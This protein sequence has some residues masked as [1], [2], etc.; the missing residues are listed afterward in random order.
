MW[1]WA[2][3]VQGCLPDCWAVFLFSMHCIEFCCSETGVFW[4]LVMVID[5]VAIVTMINEADVQ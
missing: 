4:R 3:L 2:M 5:L 1:E